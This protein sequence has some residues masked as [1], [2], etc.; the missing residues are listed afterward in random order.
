[1]VDLDLKSIR[2]RMEASEEYRKGLVSLQDILAPAEFIVTPNA[3]QIS[4][5]LARV[6]FVFTYPR[7]LQTNWLSPLINYDIQM[8]VSMFVYPLESAEV[9]GK[10]TKKSTQLESSR[11]IEQ[12]KG[13]IRSP[14]LETAIGDI[15]ELRDVLQRGELRLFQYALYFTIYGRTLE[16][17][18]VLTKQLE[19][20]L[21]GML[22]YT[23]QALLQMEDGFTSCLPICEDLLEIKRNLDTAS[24]STTF[25]FVSSTLSS[26]EGILYGIN[27]HNNS[28]IIFDRFTLE[29]ANSTVFAKAGAGKSYAV[30]LEILR[31]LMLGVDV[32]VVDPE[33]EYQ[34][35]CEAVGGVNLNISLTSHQRINPFDL[36]RGAKEDEEGEDVLRATITGVKGLIGVMLG[37]I[38]PEE[39]GVIE[40]ALYET[41]ALKDIT[42]DPQSHEN[43]PPLM[44]DFVNV[45]SNMSMP[46]AQNLGLRLQKYTTGTFAGLFNQPTNIK[47]D[48]N[49]VVFS[50]RDLEDELRPVGMYMVLSFIW[51][52]VRHREE[53][54]PRILVIDE[55]WWLMKFPD[56]AN[57]LYTFAKRARKY[58]LGLTI[59]TQDVEDFLESS[60]GRAVINN[61]SLQLLL[62]QSP[63]SIDKVAEVFHLTEGEK[64]MLLE[65][66]VGQGL[67]FAGHSHVAIEIV[68]SYTEDQIITTSPKQLLEMQKTVQPAKGE[69]EQE[70][71]TGV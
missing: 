36:A 61:S 3:L 12:E 69:E 9:M 43:P 32:I 66:N 2:A 34:K 54:K 27:R 48:R 68:A 71:K 13:M 41:Y 57:Y 55:A 7:Y 17:L 10:L 49:F 23:K 20:S 24:L 14:E 6:L 46:A 44:S 51:N 26:D 39:D 19:S 5:R 22:A 28:L 21:G 15:E 67:F 37:G 4:G 11:R 70:P 25:P 64:F 35:L 16:E 40:K 30:K 59:I 8:D 42:A 58:Y 29:N 63:A 47:L 60:Q 53:M 1:M 38:K 62:K 65:S 18:D 31:Y 33:N 45:L 56:S 52:M 50:I